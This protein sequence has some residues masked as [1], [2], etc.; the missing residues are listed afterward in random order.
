[1][2]AEIDEFVAGRPDLAVL[3]A[4]CGS[5]SVLDFPTEARRTGIDVST[6]QLE[7]N[8]VLDERIVGDLQTYRWPAAS[9]DVILCWD[10]LEHL[11]DPRGVLDNLV[12]S[13]APG[14]LLVIG[15]PNVLSPKGLIT[16]FTPLRAH[17]WFYRHIH[18]ARKAGQDDVGP[19]PAYLRMAIS[20]R[21]LRR[22]AAR[23]GLTLRQLV[24]YEG[25][26]QRRARAK[27]RVTGA[28]WRVLR[29]ATIAAT[30][31]TLDPAATDVVAIIQAPRDS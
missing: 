19:F 6:R 11:S 13:L 18:G 23:N 27:L 29:S 12:S 14:G 2:Q 10:V 1:M 4:G 7:R 15:V 16:K 31:R 8:A 21:G 17:V 24:T 25:A 20:P 30:R 26:M 5:S 3:D 9:F 22:Y 28:T